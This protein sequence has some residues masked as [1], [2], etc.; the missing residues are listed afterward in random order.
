MT[1]TLLKIL[2]IIALLILFVCIISLFFVIHYN[3]ILYYLYKINV[4]ENKINEKLDAKEDLISRIINIINRHLN[5]DFK[6]FEDFKNI[7]SSKLSNYDRDEILTTTFNEIK[8]INEDHTELNDIKSYSNIIKDIEDCDIT[9][10]GLKNINNKYVALYNEKSKKFPKNLI[11]KI[12]K[13]KIKKL[14]DNSTYNIK[15]ELN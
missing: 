14:Y 4:S 7:K 9:L 11:C 15:E 5:K 2:L 12:K 3:N 6:I 8:K 13:F 1:E 10:Y